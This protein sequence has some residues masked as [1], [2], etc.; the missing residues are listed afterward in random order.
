MRKPERYDFNKPDEYRDAMVK[1]DNQM[2]KMKMNAIV[3]TS[4][5][6]VVGLAALTVLGGS[7]E[8]SC[9]GR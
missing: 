8:A 6:V 2:R 7:V 3:G 4:V 5:A 1:Y 9:I